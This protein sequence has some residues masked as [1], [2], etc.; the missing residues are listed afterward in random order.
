[1][2]ESLLSQCAASGQMSAAQVEAHRRAGELP[3]SEAD[4]GVEAALPVAL[5][6][7]APKERRFDPQGVAIVI[8][9]A[10]AWGAVLVLSACP[11]NH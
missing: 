8:A 10:I 2:T 5:L 1:M 3:L 11:I 7:P 4:V 9:V 6:G